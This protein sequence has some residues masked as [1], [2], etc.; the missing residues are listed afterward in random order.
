MTGRFAA[1]TAR[2]G[3]RVIALGGRRIPCEFYRSDRARRVR[4]TVY[5]GRCIRVAVPSHSSL[6]AAEEFVRDKIPWILRHWRDESCPEARPVD[7]ASLRADYVQHC[8]RALA[9]ATERLRYFN[10]FYEFS[11]RRIAIKIQT[12]LWGSCSAQ[13][14]LNFN[15]RI[16]LIPGHLAD[17]VIVHELCHL[18][19]L[20]HS[21]RFWSLVARAIPDW[22]GRRRELRK[23][24]IPGGASGRH[25]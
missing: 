3:T 4:L 5:P 12:T 8:D 10:A 15:Y 20:N 17:Y 19:Q 16:A 21:P 11:Y 2:I 7:R 22:R 6:G 24:D 14:N 18:S 25:A 13:K 23:Y 9:V 1:S